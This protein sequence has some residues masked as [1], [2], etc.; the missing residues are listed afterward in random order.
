[1]VKQLRLVFAVPFAAAIGIWAVAAMACDDKSTSASAASA[2]Q[3][4]CSQMSAAECKAKMA[5]HTCPAHGA[6]AASAATAS[7]TSGCAGHA[8]Q[9]AGAAGVCPYSG[10]T[11][12]SASGCADH[13]S[14]TTASASGCSHA[15]A[16][17]ASA[18]GCAG[19]AS[20][21][22]AASGACS[23]H[24]VNAMTVSNNAAGAAGG[25]TEHN[26]GMSAGL[27]ST[28]G[29]RTASTTAARDGCDACSDLAHCEAELEAAGAT[30][31]TV[32]IKNGV[33][34]VYTAATPGQ[35]NAIQSVM[36]RRTEH[37][38]RIL[39]S[40]DKAHLC[41]DCRSMRGAMVSGRLV[42]EVVNIEGG[43][44]VLVTSED[45]QLIKRIRDLADAGRTTVKS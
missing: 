32:P 12:A 29:G 25:C 33:M 28:C 15:S 16:T 27:G 35:V 40:G 6:S 4:A 26:V 14:A 22:S 1:M 42:R 18:A 20:S 9:T 5:G 7:A 34:F 37:L 39:T 21:K 24:S 41:D 17:T 10:A 2:G 8:T 43:T 11:T 36:S 38:S 19:H 45:P 31:Q 3:S 13:A 44:L 30:M 23:A